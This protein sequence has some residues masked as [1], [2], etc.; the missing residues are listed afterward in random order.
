VHQVARYHRVVF[1]AA[2]GKGDVPGV[3]PGVG[4]IRV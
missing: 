3:C 2:K 1:A 4:R